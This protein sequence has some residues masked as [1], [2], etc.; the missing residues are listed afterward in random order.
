MIS[1]PAWQTDTVYLRTL[2]RAPKL[3]HAHGAQGQLV[4]QGQG[5]TAKEIKTP[6]G[7]AD[8]GG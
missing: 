2:R 7:E 3:A 4:R 5:A 8:P 1:G 6:E